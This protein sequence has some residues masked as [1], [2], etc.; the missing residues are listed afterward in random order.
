MRPNRIRPQP[1][2]NVGGMRLQQDY[3]EVLGVTRGASDEEIKRAFR[4][5]ARRLH[6]DVAET[7]RHEGF[8]AAV[9]AYRVL[10]H[11]KRRR[12]YDRLGLR[13]RR[14]PAPRP[15]PAAPPVV[16]ELEWWEAERGASKPIELVDTAQCAECLGRGIPRG[17]IP[18]VC[19]E[20]RGAGRLNRVTETKDIRLLEVHPCSL[21]DGRGHSRVEPCRTCA[22]CGT[23]VSP[24]TVRVR[25]PPGVNDGD[26]LAVD[27]L[28]QRFLLKVGHRP[29]D[30]RLVLA[31]SALALAAAVALLLYLLLR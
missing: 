27:G 17:V 29:R 14:E 1:R 5:L 25:T 30:S 19:I 16:L 28:A 6:P 18:A 9:E 4:G 7:P 24:A 21:C 11:P 10:S 13:P 23:T 2:S 22:G 31:V 8:Q 20:C 12:L 26:V 15:T 3:Y